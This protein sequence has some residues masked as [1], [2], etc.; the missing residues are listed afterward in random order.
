MAI[1]CRDFADDNIKDGYVLYKTAIAKAL[2]IRPTTF[3]G[4][5]G[6]NNFM[7]EA[8]A[9][10]ALRWYC[11]WLEASRFRYVFATVDG[12]WSEG[13]ED[14]NRGVLTGNC[15]ILAAGFNMLLRHLGFPIESLGFQGSNEE[16]TSLFKIAQRPAHRISSANVRGMNRLTDP[17]PYIARPFPTEK[18]VQSNA[19]HIRRGTWWPGRHYHEQVVTVSH[20][21]IFANHYCCHVR[22]LGFEFPYLDPLV[23]ARYR[24]GQDDMFEAFRPFGSFTYKTNAPTAIYYCENSA[25]SLIYEIPTAFHS[26]TVD[27]T[28]TRMRA[29][30]QYAADP[31]N[32]GSTVRMYWLVDEPD[33]ADR[34]TGPRAM[35]EDAEPHPLFVQQ[36]FH[37]CTT[38]RWARTLTYGDDR[39]RMG[40]AI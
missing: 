23:G 36:L 25:L 5:F 1:N 4:A 22:G 32:P 33:W 34:N 16:T 19:L 21:D 30:T 18:V 13:A 37:V 20:R 31:F 39:V 40:K 3:S 35:P 9:T 29:E 7:N 38:D 10:A 11:D 14:P 6:S 2:S 27:G 17:Y 15:K 12:I 24:N 28:Y 26:V 8:L